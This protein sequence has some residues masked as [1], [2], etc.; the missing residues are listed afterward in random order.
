MTNDFE[1]QNEG[2]IFLLRPLT[3]AAT[4]WLEEN[5]TGDDHQYFGHALVVEHRYIA[6]IVEGIRNDGLLVG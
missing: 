3:V 2:T 5:I 4:A 6:D 1:V